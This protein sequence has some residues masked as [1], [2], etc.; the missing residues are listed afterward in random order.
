MCDHAIRGG[1]LILLQS[2]VDHNV[3]SIE[4]TLHVHVGLGI[5]M[6]AVRGEWTRFSL[7]Y[8]LDCL[9]SIIHYVLMVCIVIP[10]LICLNSNFGKYNQQ[11]SYKTD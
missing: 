6:A 4:H 11:M 10:G 5:F 2:S 3:R 9:S 7:M 8:A 1:N